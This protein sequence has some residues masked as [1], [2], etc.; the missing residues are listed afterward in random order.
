MKNML[1]LIETLSNGGA[2]RVL[3][4]LVKY[5]N[6]DKYNI[7]VMYINN[8]GNYDEEIS[9]YV[10]VVSMFPKLKS[11]K[12]IFEKSINIIRLNLRSAICKMP[13]NLIN[14]FIIKGEYDIEIAFLEDLST[15][16]IGGIKDENIKKIA[17]VHTNLKVKNWP[18]NLGYFKN[19]DK[20]KN[21]YKNFNNIICVSRSLRDDFIDKFNIENNVIIK[22][23]PIDRESIIKKSQEQ[24]E[25]MEIS[26]NRFKMV[27]VGR[28]CPLKGYDR[29]LEIHNR[30]LKDGYI[31]ELWI[32]GE[33]EELNNIIEYIKN[34][35]LHDTVRILGFKDNPYKYMAKADMYVCPSR[36]EAYSSVVIE[37]LILNKPIVTT[38]CTG[39]KEILGDSEYGLITSNDSEGLFTGIKR[40]IDDKDMLN[41]Y[42]KKSYERSLYFNIV[43]RV[44]EIESIFDE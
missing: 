26:N 17:W 11:G 6:K 44:K 19:E 42:R 30:L 2:E 35:N 24:I 14:K 32:L 34:N 7:T 33:G 43:D 13:S 37:A 21:A 41:Y 20:Q 3:C 25:D 9:K 29:L 23:N 1:I 4:N 40:M 8:T 31:H 15:R 38:N 10:Q 16:I 18:V 36:T 12:N 22:Y 5:L 28:L 27:S 39:M